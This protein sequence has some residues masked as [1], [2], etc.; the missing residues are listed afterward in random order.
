MRLHEINA[1]I[2]MHCHHFMKNDWMNE[3]TTTM[4]IKRIS[5]AEVNYS[6]LNICDRYSYIIFFLG[7]TSCKSKNGKSAAVP[8][9][10]HLFFTHIF[11]ELRLCISL[12]FL[13]HVNRGAH[14]CCCIVYLFVCL[15]Q[16]RQKTIEKSNKRRRN[17]D[18]DYAIWRCI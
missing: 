18:I 11:C 4:S 5:T 17:T 2:A 6:W 15:F 14:L 3:W 8:L 7:G 1:N 16:V 10:L 13:P 12:F 9:E